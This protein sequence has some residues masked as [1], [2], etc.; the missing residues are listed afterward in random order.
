MTDEEKKSNEIAAEYLMGHDRLEVTYEE[1]RE[2]VMTMAEWKD[3][4]IQEIIDKEIDRANRYHDGNLSLVQKAASVRVVSVLS[5]YLGKEF[6]KDR[7]H[8]GFVTLD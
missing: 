2:A 3:Q 1:M 5:E 6:P 4:Q 8:F 7:F